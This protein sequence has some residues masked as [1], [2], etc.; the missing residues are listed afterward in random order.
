[1]PSRTHFEQRMSDQLTKNF[2]PKILRWES[3]ARKKMSVNLLFQN[4]GGNASNKNV[5][6]ASRIVQRLVRR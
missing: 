3:V 5:K 6:Q 1:M 2:G 4:F